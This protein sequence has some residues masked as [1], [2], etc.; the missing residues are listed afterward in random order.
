MVTVYSSEPLMSFI[1]PGISNSPIHTEAPWASFVVDHNLA[2]N[3]R[4]HFTKL[5]TKM[6][7][8]KI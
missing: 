5:L 4:D 7:L 6:F 2:I 3:P 8:T 1:K